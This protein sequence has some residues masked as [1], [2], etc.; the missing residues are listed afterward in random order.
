MCCAPLL[1]IHPS[2]AGPWAAMAALWG[3]GRMVLT[4]TH[5]GRLPCLQ[6]PDADI[7]QS[8]FALV[9]DLAKV[10]APHI[11]PALVRTG[12]EWHCCS[13]VLCWPSHCVHSLEQPSGEVN[14]P[15]VIDWHSPPCLCCCSQQAEVFH[16][17]LYNLEPQM[18]N[19]R[20]LSACNNAAWCMG[21]Q[22]LPVLEAAGGPCCLLAACGSGT[23][24]PWCRLAT[25]MHACMHV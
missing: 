6:D 16:S 25:C 22:R 17:A 4:A 12:E 23:G 7:R 11:K 13:S 14:T 2:L 5:S 1:R 19:Q 20:T 24:C 3:P 15:T 18:V 9:G 10:C 8:G 21:E